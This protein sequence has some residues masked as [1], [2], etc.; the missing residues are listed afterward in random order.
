[1]EWIS[2][3]DKLPDRNDFKMC[4]VLMYDATSSGHNPMIGFYDST[5]QEGCFY[6]TMI[7]TMLVRV[8]P[9]HYIVIPD[10]LK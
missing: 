3:K 1:M 7:R 2:V 10:F 9:T 6:I 8:H 5:D 4:N